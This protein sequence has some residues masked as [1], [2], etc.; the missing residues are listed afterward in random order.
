MGTV[1]TMVFHGSGKLKTLMIFPSIF[2]CTHVRHTKQ[3]EILTGHR[4]HVEFD[5]PTPLQIDSETI[6]DVTAYDISAQTAGFS[7]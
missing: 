5:R 3:V 4:I 2:S 7:C 1:S 6:P